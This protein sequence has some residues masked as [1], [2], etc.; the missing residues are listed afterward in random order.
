VRAEGE[1]CFGGGGIEAVAARC[2]QPAAKQDARISDPTTI[3]R[4]RRQTGNEI[5]TAPILFFLL[6]IFLEAIGRFIQAN[7]GFAQRFGRFARSLRLDFLL[8]QFANSRELHVKFLTDIFPGFH[9]RSFFRRPRLRRTAR[10]GFSFAS[11][12]SLL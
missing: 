9:H 11:N 4:G 6:E 12:F 10:N 7:G 8:D 1:G 2:A 5:T 3:V